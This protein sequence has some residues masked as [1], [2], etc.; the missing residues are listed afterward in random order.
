MSPR[1]PCLALILALSLSAP[2]AAQPGVVPPNFDVSLLA[3]GIGINHGLNAMDVDASGNLYIVDEPPTPMGIGPRVHRITRNGAVFLDHA[4]FFGDTGQMAYHPLDGRV[5]IVETQPM[6]PVINAIVWRIDATGGATQIMNVPVVAEGFTIDNQGNMYFGGMGIQGQGLYRKPANGLALQY[7]GPGF[8]NNRILQSL[9][10]GDVLI[11]D[12]NEVRR[13][14][15]MAVNTLPYYVGPPIFPNTLGGVN[16]LARTWF[17]QIG[18]GAIIGVNTFGT[19]CFCGDGLAVTAD[20]IGNDEALFATE[21]YNLPDTGMQQVASGIRQDMYWATL[22]AG[23]GGG[24]LAR[25]YRVRQLPAPG[26]HGTLDIDV[27]GGLL[28]LDL[29]GDAAGG[30]PFLVGV[31]PTPAVTPFGG[32]FIPPFGILGLDPLALDY[33]VFLDGIGVFLPPHPFAVIPPGG[34]FPLS[35]SVPPLGMAFLSEAVILDPQH[36][37]NGLFTITNVDPFAL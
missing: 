6:L 28:T 24:Q 1:N 13:W 33:L 34:H 11:A 2:A 21:P 7:L 36:A 25:L 8:G 18:Q 4:V 5:F 31:R 3:G 12:G 22:V 26:S 20:L 30:D 15:P 9:V 37:V 35:M 19:F 27:Q 10:S 32:L 29:Y 17:N 23:P 14:T 16:S